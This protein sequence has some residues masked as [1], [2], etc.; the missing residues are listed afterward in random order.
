M[1]FAEAVAV[2]HTAISDAQVASLL[3]A[4]TIPQVVELITW[5]SFEHAGQMLGALVGDEPATAEQRDALAASVA[6]QARSSR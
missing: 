6:G 2:D 5:I 1:A 3:G 4:L